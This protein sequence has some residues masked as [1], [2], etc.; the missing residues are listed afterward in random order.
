MQSKELPE[1]DPRE[2]FITILKHNFNQRQEDFPDENEE[3]TMLS[4]MV[5]SVIDVRKE[6]DEQ[7]RQD[8]TDLNNLKDFTQF[9]ML[10]YKPLLY[11]EKQELPR[12]FSEYLL[13]CLLEKKEAKE[14]IDYDYL[15]ENFSTCFK[16]MPEEVKKDLNE[17][18]DLFEWSKLV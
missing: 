8:L 16:N 7:V 9:L 14:V 15:K 10:D 4:A 6:L 13:L 1:N 5:D 18:K 12:F 3:K 11:A 2:D 17:E